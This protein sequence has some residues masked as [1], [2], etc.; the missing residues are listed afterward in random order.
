MVAGRA[1]GSATYAPL[2]LKGRSDNGAPRYPKWRALV[3]GHARA[4][5]RR[6]P[7]K[8]AGAQLFLKAR[9]LNVRPYV[10][11]RPGIPATSPA[12]ARLDGLPRTKGPTLAMHAGRTASIARAGPKPRRYSGGIG[13]A[14]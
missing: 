6:A 10:S 11:L 4:R 7:A 1:P 13:C 12:A 2:S 5:D 9:A 3:R 8:C 14:T